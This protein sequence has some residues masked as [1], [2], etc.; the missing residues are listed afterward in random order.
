MRA[1]IEAI[2]AATD[3]SGAGALAADSPASAHARPP[4]PGDWLVVGFSG[5]RRLADDEVIRAALRLAVDQLSAGGR[6]LMAIA[7][8]ASGADTLFLE[9]IVGR[10]LPL[11]LILPFP[12]ARF[13]EDFTETEWQRVQPLLK[14][15]TSVEELSGPESDEQAYL[16]T[17][18]LTVDRCDVLIAVWDGQ[19][20]RGVG[21]TGEIVEYARAMSKPLLLIDPTTGSI[22]DERGA[23]GR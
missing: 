1:P 13:R 9:E 21:G 15:A 11:L 16:A 8:A 23:S 10:S 17:G 18:V 2:P 12:L 14:A 6:R 4:A 22:L 3:A 20:A 19:P 5:H 7:S